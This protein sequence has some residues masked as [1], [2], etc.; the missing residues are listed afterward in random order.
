MVKDARRQSVSVIVALDGLS[1]SDIEEKVRNEYLW[2]DP[3][4]EE[5]R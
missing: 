5:K 2:D 4:E 1:V 3:D